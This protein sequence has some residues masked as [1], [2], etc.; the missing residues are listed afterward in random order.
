[1]QGLARSAG[2]WTSSMNVV[3]DNENDRTPGL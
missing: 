1:M 2:A 3:V